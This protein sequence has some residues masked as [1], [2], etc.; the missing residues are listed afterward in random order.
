MLER[1]LAEVALD[2]RLDAVHRLEVAAV[3]A[4]DDVGVADGTLDAVLGG[5]GRRRRRR[6]NCRCDGRTRGG[7]GRG[8]RGEV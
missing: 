7:R 6:K 8:V 4:A 3:D 1:L 5:R 2:R